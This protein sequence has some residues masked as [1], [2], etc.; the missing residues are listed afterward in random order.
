MDNAHCPFCDILALRPEKIHFKTKHFFA[1]T[2]L[3]PVNDGHILIVSQ[4]HISDL[5]SMN[6]KES[7]NLCHALRCGKKFL[8]ERLR[9]D[10][11][12]LGVNSGTAAGQSVF[13]LHFHLIYR[14]TGDVPDPYGGVIRS[15]MQGYKKTPRPPWLPELTEDTQHKN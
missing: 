11:Y 15:I 7:R 9:P 13:H 14:F 1:L 6:D 12:N 5:F 10:G 4:R 8:E 3:W 2:P